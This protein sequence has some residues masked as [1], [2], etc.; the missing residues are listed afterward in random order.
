[1][2]M[3]LSMHGTVFPAGSVTQPWEMLTS[4]VASSGA[5]L[6]H[7]AART[8]VMPFHW[9]H[10]HLVVAALMAVCRMR[11]VCAG[12]R[13]LRWVS[14]ALPGALLRAA[15]AP[16]AA[17]AVEAAPERW[18]E[19]V[20]QAMTVTAGFLVASYLAFLEDR[21]MRCAYVATHVPARRR[22]RVL[23]GVPRS[24]DFWLH[25]ALP[26]VWCMLMCSVA[27]ARQYF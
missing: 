20:P 12:S 2:H 23:A 5:A 8:P 14:A 11:G 26:P 10:Q 25:F 4:G 13:S 21:R 1:M 18:C 15:G 9:Q 17:A 16:G 7:M 24:A 19:G 3:I 6:V 27:S 22:R